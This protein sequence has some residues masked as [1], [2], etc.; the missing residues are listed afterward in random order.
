MFRLFARHRGDAPR[1]RSRRARHRGTMA[2]IATLALAVL[3]AGCA[4][5]TS[6]SPATINTSTSNTSAPVT[7]A[8][9]AVDL[10][11]TIET[12]IQKV[13]PSVVEITSSNGNAGGLGFGIIPAAANEAIGSGEILTSDGYIVTND[14]VVAGFSQ[15]TVTLANGQNFPAQLVGTDPNDDLAVLK[16]NGSNLPTITLGDSG[17]VRVG[18]FVIA[19]G[20]PLG[21]AQSATFGIVSATNR[22]ATEGQNG[23]AQ[24]LVGLIQTSAPINPGNSGGALVDLSGKLIGIPTLAAV[25]PES[26]TAANGIG[27]AIPSNRVQFI[28]QQ[29][30]KYGQVRSTG[31]GFLGVETQDVTPIIAEQYNLPVQSG[32]L[33]VGFGKDTAGVSPAQQAGVKVG[34]IITAIDGTP[35]DSTS[36]L[37]AILIS[38]DPGA[39]VRVTVQRGNQQ[40]NI[41]VKLGERPAN[42]N[43]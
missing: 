33:V 13:Q 11:S 27:F 15:F 29:L 12:V 1:P 3:L 30:I 40:L 22:N 19:I 8:A 14:H 23:P 16:I 39:T 20:S 6:P 7:P 43:G 35:V 10:Q 42:L 9:Q 18:Q 36:S 26:G 32:A 17:K 31:Q 41:S 37:A 24:E 28:A 2:I 25:D 4:G 21:L 5:S 38:K 34:D